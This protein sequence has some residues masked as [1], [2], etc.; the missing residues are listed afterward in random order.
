MV[1]SKSAPNEIAVFLTLMSIFVK[2]SCLALKII[3]NEQD[4]DFVF[5]VSPGKLYAKCK[6]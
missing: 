6:K 3:Y 1:G 2:Q 5:T 4:T